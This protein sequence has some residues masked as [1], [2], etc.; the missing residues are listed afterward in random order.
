M[1]CLLIGFVAMLSSSTCLVVAADVAAPDVAPIKFERETLDNGLRVIYAPMTNAPVVHIRVMYH[2]GSKDEAPDRQGFA[3][4]FEHMMFRGSAH[5]PSE[6]H[7]KLINGVGGVSNA[8]TSFDQTT[9]VNTVPTTGVQMALWLEADR[10]ASFKVSDEVFKTERNVVKEEW[11][12]RVANQPYGTMNEDLFRLAF[13]THNYKWMPIGDMDHLA[14]AQV[15][16]LQDFHDRYYVPNNACLIIAGEF[17]VSQVKEWVHKYYNWIPRSADIERVTRPEEAQTQQHEKTVT[18]PALPFTR[19]SMAYKNPAYRSNDHL[20]IE[21]LTEILGGGRSSR[22]YQALVANDPVAAQASM[23]DYQ[24]EDPAVIFVGLGVLPGKDAAEAI[25]RA[26]AEFKKVIDEGVT[27]EEL[28]KAKTQTRVA[29]VQSRATAESVATVLGEEE[30]FGGDADRANTYF[31]RLAKLTPED[32]K[33]VAAKYLVDDHLTVVE[34]KPGP[35]ATQPSE[36]KS[37]LES[38]KKIEAA[39]K[40]G[41]PEAD[42]PVA[43]ARRKIEFPDDFPTSA[44]MNDEVIA[45]SFEKGKTQEVNGVQVI[46]MHD[47]R[48]PVVSATLVLRGGSHA[49]PADKEGVASLTSS[50]LSRG[51]AGMS[52]KE[53]A[54]AL[55]SHGVSVGA[56]DDGDVTRLTAYGPAEEI[57]Y[58]IGLLK[59]VAQQPDFPE[60]EFEKLKRQSMQG[61]LGQLSDPGSVANRELDTLVY[62]EG[63]L[64]KNVTPKSLMG[65]TLDDVKDYYKTT[66]R[67]DGA[68]MVFAGDITQDKADELAKTLLDGFAQGKPPAAN[69]DVAAPTERKIILVDNPDGQQAVVRMGVKAYDLSDDVRF[70]GSIAG[71]VLSS[72]IDSRLNRVLRAE[73][74]LTYGAYGYFRPSRHGGAFELSIETKPESVDDAI[75]STLQVLQRMKDADITDAELAEAKRRTAGTM[76]LETQTIQQQAGR[77]VDT[78][79]NGYPIDYYDNYAKRIAQVTADQVRDVMAKYVV[80]DNIDIVV[81]GPASKVASQLEKVGEPSVMPMPLAEMQ[82]MMGGLGGAK[83]GGGGMNTKPATQPTTQPMK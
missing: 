49:V 24:L 3:H 30:V 50:M 62:G 37:E 13:K 80:D 27:A 42:Q 19:I 8:F 41:A 1:K 82:K 38:A 9:Y 29:L 45:A 25:D 66:F 53:I 48:L 6:Q 54:E 7:M 31:A 55:E 52:A 33:A 14:A 51:A 40:P 2:V 74:G 65:I 59:K 78:V 46:T 75:T 67:P 12:L 57:E 44:P 4:M 34:Y 70:A 69:Y 20:A 28:D 63:P 68:I 11:R 83:M 61:L 71:Q 18:K 10:M 26:K 17:D 56:S 58:A 32:I 5:V 22:L 16:E 64:G 43:A 39:T 36:I 76:V 15:Q 23:G 72:G 79:L 81:V 77:R 60:E 47:D 21:C 35:A 73:K